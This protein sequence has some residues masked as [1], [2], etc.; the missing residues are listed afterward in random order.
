MAD[1]YKVLGVPSNASIQ[2]IKKA[3]RK[4]ALKY[5]PD[6]HQNSSS[7]EK[8]K[9]EKIFKEVTEAYEVLGDEKK[10]RMYDQMGPDA[11]RQSSSG[12]GGFEGFSEAG[13]D[14]SSIFE[15]F[16]SNFGSSSQPTVSKGRDVLIKISITLEDAFK[17]VNQSVEFSTI[18]RCDSC[19]GTGGEKG[20]KVV[21][22]TTCHGKGEVGISQGFFMVRQTCKRCQG[23]GTYIAVLCKKCRGS[24]CMRD[25][26]VLDFRVPPGIEHESQLRLHGE[27]EVGERGG[28]CGDAI[29]QVN[30]QSHSLFRRKG[31]NLFMNYPLSIS[32]AALGCVVQIPTIE[33]EQVSVTFREGTQ[34]KEKT[35]VH[36]KGMPYS[37]GRGDLI[38]EADVYVPLKLTQRQKE[39]LQDFLEEEENKPPETTGFFAKLK[40]FFKTL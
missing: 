39:L 33:G 26:R 37:S 28:P 8:Q 19:S 1:Y 13:F 36:N 5:H 18:V 17:G 20:S 6:Q 24:G 25:R 2:D 14:F 30:V 35:V 31:A 7:A 22:C 29:I 10:R 34:F 21:Q 9:A 3:Y 16:F 4:L 11:F 12:G 40:N 27:G 32:Q 15:D 23:T 38:I